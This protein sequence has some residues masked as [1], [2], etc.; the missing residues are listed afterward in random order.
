MNARPTRV[1]KETLHSR[2]LELLGAAALV[3]LALL[4]G[5]S[6][7]SAYG[8][9]ATQES[10]RD[11][12]VSVEATPEATPTPT[13]EPTPTP[14]PTPEP[15]PTPT[16]QTSPTP[17]PTPTPTPE[18]TPAGFTAWIYVVKRIDRDGD[19]N[20]YEDREWPPAWEFEVTFED[21]AGVGSGTFET[22]YEEGGDWGF[23][24]S[25]ESAHVV[26]SEVQQEGYRLLRARCF[27]TDYNVEEEVPSILEGNSLS[28]DVAIDDLSN[29]YGCG[30]LNI[31]TSAAGLET[32]APTVTL[33]PTSAIGA[34][35]NDDPVGW[36]LPFAALLGLLAGALVL[37]S[38]WPAAN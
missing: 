25:G 3:A 15:T 16:P 11:G 22:Y 13:P 30:F 12:Y 35:T 36:Q 8:S 10:I 19:P 26:L 33:P 37:K 2:F 7:P 14:T 17:S 31:P 34:S 28:F 6:I 1:H 29:D 20:T 24:V 4:P 18:A 38:R 9:A 23:D 21:D 5:T 27:M 32:T